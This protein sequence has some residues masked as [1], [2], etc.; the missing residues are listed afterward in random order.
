M[1]K[2]S[3]KYGTYMIK[4]CEPKET[5]IATRRYGLRH[6]GMVTRDPSSESALSA[7]NISIAT[8]TVSESVDAFTLPASK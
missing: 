4:K 7:L 8:R 6:G 2:I 1:E 5:S 3:A